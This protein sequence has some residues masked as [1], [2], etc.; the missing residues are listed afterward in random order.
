MV[1]ALASLA[2]LSVSCGFALRT[3]SVADLLPVI[4]IDR[5][6]ARDV[7]V[8]IERQA[9]TQR[10]KLEESEQ[11]SS[12][13]LHRI[14]EQLNIRS[15]RLDRLGRPIEYMV[16][17]KWLVAMEEDSTLSLHATENVGLA[18]DALIGFEKEKAR[19]LMLL[20]EQLAEQLLWRLA[21]RNKIRGSNAAADS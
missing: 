18:E 9:E 15:T 16:S 6:L 1:V 8:A 5:N 17:V 2:G 3:E 21:L 13:L 20:R 19:V 14:D 11:A 4:S 7:R 10:V 12:N